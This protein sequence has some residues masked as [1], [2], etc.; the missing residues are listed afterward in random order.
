MLAASDSNLTNDSWEGP[1]Y[2]VKGSI[3]M[4][5]I[6]K[7]AR[8]AFVECAERH[9]E[10]ILKRLYVR[11]LKDGESLSNPEVLEQLGITVSVIIGYAW[12]LASTAE[13]TAEI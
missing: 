12:G 13:K 9:L 10:P 4:T 7:I 6:I 1:L 2:I 11:E 3:K 5:E 8:P